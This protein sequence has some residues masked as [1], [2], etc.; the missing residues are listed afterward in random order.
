MVKICEGAGLLITSCNYKVSDSVFVAR[1]EG[2]ESWGGVGEVGAG[3]KG[4]RAQ[5]SFFDRF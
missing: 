1:Q 4:I 3:W 5:K 2:G